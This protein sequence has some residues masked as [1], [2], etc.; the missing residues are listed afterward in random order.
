MTK[1]SLLPTALVLMLLNEDAGYIR[2]LRRGAFTLTI[3]I[4]C[5]DIAGKKTAPVATADTG[6]NTTWRP[7]RFLT[8]FLSA[9][10]ESQSN[11][12]RGLLP[13]ACTICFASELPGTVRER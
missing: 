12:P 6:A 1:A 10:L 9:R 4:L 8:R 3:A 5:K 13:L 2:G 11:H 7:M